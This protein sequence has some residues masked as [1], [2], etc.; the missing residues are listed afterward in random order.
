M[1]SGLIYICLQASNGRTV[2]RSSAVSPRSRAPRRARTKRERRIDSGVDD[3]GGWDWRWTWTFSLSRAMAVCSCR[4]TK[5]KMV[6]DLWCRLIYSVVP[7]VSDTACLL[8]CLLGMIKSRWYRLYHLSYLTHHGHDDDDDDNRE[9]EYDESSKFGIIFFLTLT[10]LCIRDY[11]CFKQLSKS[12]TFQLHQQS[13]P[14]SS[15]PLY[16]TSSHLHYRYRFKLRI[17]NITKI[18]KRKKKNGFASPVLTVLALRTSYI[19]QRATAYNDIHTVYSLAY[20]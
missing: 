1:G 5:I 2:P 13:I 3:E 14:L 7:P 15:H 20:G 12:V 8:A 18:I 9:K 10:V 4:Y 6:M 11:V 19:H 16:N 17:Q